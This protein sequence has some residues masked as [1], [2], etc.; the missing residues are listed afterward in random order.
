MS[1]LIS[2]S[3]LFDKRMMRIP[4]YQRGYAWREDQLE[5]FWNDIKDLTEDKSH[6]TGMISLKKFTESEENN[7]E[8]AKLF[9]EKGYVPFYVVDGQQRLTTFIILL[10]C[11]LD[12]IRNLPDN[13]KKKK[14]T[15]D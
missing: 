3:E 6:Y 15:F 9:K 2:F 11:I 5:D 1:D 4:D 13:N 7:S 8:D 10:K 14:K 12:E